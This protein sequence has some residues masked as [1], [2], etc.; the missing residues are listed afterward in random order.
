M[1]KKK[2]TFKEFREVLENIANMPLDIYGW[3]GILNAICLC[4]RY[5]AN[6][7][8][9]LGYDRLAQRDIKIARDITEYL[10]N[11]GYYQA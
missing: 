2:M 4:K 8:K 7:A 11:N 10:E 9:Q 5:C 3:D 6:N 1:S